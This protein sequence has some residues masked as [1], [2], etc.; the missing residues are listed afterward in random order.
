MVPATRGHPATSASVASVE[1]NVFQ[2]TARRAVRKAS[3]VF[4]S[5]L[6]SAAEQTVAPDRGGISVFQGSTSHQPPRQVNGSVRRRRLGIRRVEMKVRHATLLNVFGRP[7][8]HAGFTIV[9]AEVELEGRSFGP[10]FS[11][12]ELPSVRIPPILRAPVEKHYDVSWVRARLPHA[13]GISPEPSEAEK[14]LLWVGFVAVPEGQE[15]GI[16]FWCSDFYGK[17]SL[18]FSD[19][20]TDEASKAN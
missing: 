12:S 18:M 2:T 14:T 15:E 7:A 8:K 5:R 6:R 11:L 3:G 4:C 10:S 1:L 16:A 17:T 19:A 20:E 9:P 13:F